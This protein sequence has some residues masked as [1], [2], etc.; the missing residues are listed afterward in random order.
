MRPENIQKRR[1][2]IFIGSGISTS[3]TLLN[4][5]DNLDQTSIQ[6]EIHIT[7]L[8]KWDEFNKGLPYGQ[9]SGTSVLLITSLRNFLPEPELTPFIK[10]LNENKA[11]LIS[12][13]LESGG[14]LSRSWI[15][16]NQYEIDHNQWE[17]LFI[18]RFFFGHYI[19]Q[20]VNRR[21]QEVSKTHQLIVEFIKGK[22]T[23]LEKH[24]DYWK[25]ILKNGSLLEAEKVVLSIGSLPMRY[26][27]QENRIVKEK[28]LLFINDIYTNSLQRTL[29]EIKDFLKKR[30]GKKLNV[31]IIGANA[32][33][34]EILYK[35]ND[36]DEVA[37][38][39][40]KYFF[41]S[42][43]GVLPDS[44]VAIEKQKLFRPAN[45]QALANKAKLRASDISEAAFK[46]LKIA[47]K[48]DLG[49]FSTVNII[50]NAFGKLLGNLSAQELKNFACYHGN[51]IGRFQ[52]CAGLHYT[53][54]VKILKEAG[55]FAHIAGRFSAVKQDL[56]DGYHLEYVDTKTKEKAT[57]PDRID[58]VINCSGS[59][60]LSSPKVPKLIWNIVQKEYV[61]PNESNI[62]FDVNDYLEADKNFHIMGP[63][64]AGNVIRNRPVWHV[65][66][67]GRIIWLSSVLGKILSNPYCFEDKLT[68]L[69]LRVRDLNNEEDRKIYAANLSKYWN[70]NPYSSL[71]YLS[72]D[73]DANDRLIAFE[74]LKDKEIMALMPMVLRKVPLIVDD[75]EY[76]DVISPYGYSGP[77]FVEGID[78]IYIY[79]FWNL[80]DDW[81]LKNKVVT[82][83]IRFSLNGNHNYYSGR[84]ELT[85]KNVVGTIHKDWNVN[86]N[87]F[88]SK[89]RNNYRKAL[90]HDL[91]FQIFKGKDIGEKEIMDFHDIYIETMDRN[92]AS[93]SYFYKLDFFKNLIYTL[94]EKFILAFSMK[95]NSMASTE[96]LICHEN[97]IYAFL[98]GTRQE[99][100]PCRP[101][102]FLRVEIIKWASE[103]GI[104]NYI[105]GG[106]RHDD[107][108]LYKHK[109]SLFPRD[110]D[111]MYYTGRK[112]VL[113][114]INRKLNTIQV[115]DVQ[116]EYET[117][118]QDYFPKYRF[119]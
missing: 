40:D 97:R 55:R 28:N 110:Q 23:D 94:P 36:I 102:D 16:K 105:L 92:R 54:T 14:Q 44:E 80:V 108:G 30:E 93:T 60:N 58:I 50:S 10:W 66:H 113:E 95:N 79:A 11:S 8:D 87:G 2:I 51:E 111:A 82:E 57:I 21:I 118:D 74:L 41:V 19:D 4:F 103:N 73:L 78:E 29:A 112:I 53:N 75:E 63:L 101:N 96:L 98:G 49:A 91:Q 81:Y 48:M 70:S 69:E 119:W 12:E 38:G 6:R 85:L 61:H 116:V 77:L 13:F 1:D 59:M 31:A 9:R 5:L 62:G 83:F 89:V 24:D 32:S 100:F 43:Y 67:C 46:D 104:K 117:V 33:A 86:W 114:D 45:L 84:L 34:L 106:G 17:E 72:H 47:D 76:F 25:V 109:K 107:D 56:N 88:L 3:F 71:P 35:L 15:A 42:T 22:A 27:W 52:R 65:E 64:L 39:I 90:E 7:V 115:K 26:L 18:P 20:K 99:F 37:S 68:C